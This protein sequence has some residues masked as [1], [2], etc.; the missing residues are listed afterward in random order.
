MMFARGCTSADITFNH[1]GRPF[2]SGI[3]YSS[4]ILY[5]GYM[6]SDCTITVEFKDIDITDLVLTIE[7][8]RGHLSAS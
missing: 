1:L 3:I 8:E 6:T 5:S 2:T 4:I 7:K